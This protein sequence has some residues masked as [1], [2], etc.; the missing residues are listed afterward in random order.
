MWK[1]FP[2]FA[3][4]YHFVT[5]LHL[6]VVVLYSCKSLFVPSRE[7]SISKNISIS[8]RKPLKI[9]IENVTA[10]NSFCTK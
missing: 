5:S 1:I 10:E 6:H 9:N 2:I 3:Y 4:N 7:S 8:F